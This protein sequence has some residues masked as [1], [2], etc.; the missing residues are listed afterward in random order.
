M[1]ERR[2]E[3]LMKGEERRSETRGLNNAN[4]ASGGRP[5]KRMSWKEEK[6]KGK[7]RRDGRRCEKTKKLERRGEGEMNL[8]KEKNNSG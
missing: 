5:K 3:K 6:R 8:K 1:E 7:R 4:T 2:G